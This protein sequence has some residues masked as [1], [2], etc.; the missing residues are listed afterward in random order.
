MSLCGPKTQTTHVHKTPPDGA[1]GEI[2]AA[3]IE[4]GSQKGFK[5]NQ[6]MQNEM[7]WNVHLS[8]ELLLKLGTKP[9]FI[10]WTVRPAPF[11]VQLQRQ[12]KTLSIPAFM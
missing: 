2:V 7:K 3:S 11:G 9:H 6:K 1:A 10:F 4:S 12:K 5:S 8:P